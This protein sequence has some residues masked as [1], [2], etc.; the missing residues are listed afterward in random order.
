MRYRYLLNE[1]KRNNPSSDVGVNNVSKFIP[2]EGISPSAANNVSPEQ[3]P[4]S[5]IE[6]PKLLSSLPLD[7]VIGGAL[8]YSFRKLLLRK[9]EIHWLQLMQGLIHEEIQKIAIRCRK[10]NIVLEMQGHGVNFKI[11]SS[12]CDG[13]SPT[14]FQVLENPHW[15]KLISGPSRHLQFHSHFT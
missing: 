5:N 15:K 8:R 7:G 1:V 13:Y 6:I 14:F 10:L 2:D 11:L 12:K 3:V 4:Y 9:P